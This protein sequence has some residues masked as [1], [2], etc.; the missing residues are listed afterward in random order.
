[1]ANEESRARLLAKAGKNGK[2]LCNRLRTFQV[3][4]EGNVVGG[5]KGRTKVFP[6]EIIEAGTKVNICQKQYVCTDGDLRDTATRNVLIEVDQ[7]EPKTKA[8][9]D[10]ENK[11][12]KKA[13]SDSRK[14]LG[15]RRHLQI[16]P[17]LM[18]V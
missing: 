9:W 13:S 5:E 14:N 6:G 16:M 15:L 4:K 18:L 3:F 12:K 17:T 2:K 7:A 10:A 11:A 8:Q 1:M